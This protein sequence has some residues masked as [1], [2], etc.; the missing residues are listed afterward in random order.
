MNKWKQNSFHEISSRQLLIIL[1]ISMAF[2]EAQTIA[3]C[4]FSLYNL[5]IF[6][7][8]WLYS[9]ARVSFSFLMIFH[10]VQI[11]FLILHF[12]H[13]Q[14][15]LLSRANDLWRCKKLKSPKKCIARL[16]TS[17]STRESENASNRKKSMAVK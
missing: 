17:D 3:I 4:Q 11:R 5:T 1:M 13:F 8:I 9:S 16:T 12:L 6:R 7:K 2:F 10:K 15:W 14:R